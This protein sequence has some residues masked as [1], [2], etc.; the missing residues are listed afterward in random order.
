MSDHVREGLKTAVVTGASAGI[1][2]SAVLGL[3][4]AGFHV[5]AGARRMEAMEDLAGLTGG[6]VTA[7]KLDVSDGGSVA[8]FGANVRERMGRHGAVDVL[9]NNAGY[10]VS[11]P[12]EGL[13]VEALRQ[14]FETN[15]F[16]L[17]AVTLEF[18]SEMRRRGSGRI[19]NISS[20]V[21]KVAFPFQGPYCASKH[22][23]EALSDSMR[24]ELGIYGVKVVLVEPGPIRTDFDAVLSKHVSCA[25][26][27]RG[28]YPGLEGFTR[29]VRRFHQSAPGPE[30]V[31]RAIVRAATARSPRARYRVPAFQVGAAI[32][33]FAVL[34]TVVADFM[35]RKIYGHRRP[36]G[37]EAPAGEAV[38]E[39]EAIT[40]HG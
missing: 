2:R 24:I 11:G 29:M 32:P 23:L 19:I 17:H 40:S 28:A 10:G 38:T 37:V 12:V 3:A 5:Y 31:A 6:R 14:Q 7:L 27:V 33:F 34:P 18:V 1:G 8:E 20:I 25:E 35:K 39:A 26:G 22:A 13:T 15:F 16:G 4:R 30:A 36:V 21:G 9:V